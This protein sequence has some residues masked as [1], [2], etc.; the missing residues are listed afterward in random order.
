MQREER[1]IT[2][3]CSE[4]TQREIQ[5]LHPTQQWGNFRQSPEN[6]HRESPDPDG[7]PL[8]KNSHHTGTSQPKYKTD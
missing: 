2:I 7:L 8:S 4:I 5:K 3:L 6:L 1:D